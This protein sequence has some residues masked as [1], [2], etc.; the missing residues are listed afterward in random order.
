[1]RILFL[2]DQFPYPLRDGGNLRSFHILSGLTRL[3]DVTLIAHKPE[4]DGI[5]PSFPLDCKVIPVR[6][7]S[8]SSRIA[9]GLL[10]G[11]RLHGSLFLTK[12]WSSALLHAAESEIQSRDFDAIHFNHLDT[13]CYA[14]MRDWRPIKIFDTHNFLSGM[15]RQASQGTASWSRRCLFDYEARQLKAA[16]SEICLSMDRN[17][18]CSDIDAEL[19][20]SICPQGRFEVVPNG[21]DTHFFQP[22][23]DVP[24]ECNSLVFIGAMNYFPNTQAASFF[25]DQIF[26]R[27]HTNGVK[28]SF[29]GR[30][31]SPEVAARHNGCS[32]IVTG[33]VDDVRPYVHAS[34][35]VIVPLQHG[36]G[37][38]LKI[39]EAFAM[40]K[41]VISTS[42]G[43]EG[44]PVEHGRELMLADTP[45]DF[46]DCIDMLLANPKRRLELGR[47]ARK[48]VVDHFEWQRIQSSVRECYAR[49]S[50]A[51]SELQTNHNKRLSK[52]R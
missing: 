34:Q 52:V 45:Q 28:V 40:S 18:V 38:R 43:A 46:A 33:E 31:P 51:R 10:H 17:L 42:R 2:T 29:V 9:G 3:H 14:M 1:M 22:D 12:N 19:F 30:K 35:I 15:S 23:R 27:I 41:A 47:T 11:V 37:T 8:R 20:R 50:F 24:S 48:F 25:C 16:E 26:P 39:L 44:I 4:D 49:E 13:A 5:L 7:Q 6:K 36:S 32:V 21:V